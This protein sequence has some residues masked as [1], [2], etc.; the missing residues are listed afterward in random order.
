MGKTI[1]DILPVFSPFSKKNA[2]SAADSNKKRDQ[3]SSVFMRW[4]WLKAN[5]EVYAEYGRQDNYWNLQDLE[6]EAAYSAAYIVGFRKLLP[7]K[8]KKNEYIQ[9]NLELTQLE[10]NSATRSRK[11]QGWYLNDQVRAGYTNQGQLL[12]AGIGTGSN[13]Q[14]LNVSWVRGLKQ[15][16]IQF[17]RFVHNND[18]HNSYI[19][20]IRIHWV[21]MSATLHADWN[22][23]HL[24]FTA[25][26]GFVNS[27]NYEWIYNV[28][29]Y[30][31]FWI[32]GEDDL[33]IHG[34][35][36]LMYRF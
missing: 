8:R 27:M 5:A 21:D 32:K 18:F 25:K 24:V 36:G 3:H 31:D 30:P 2:G 10:L 16:G 17:E 22:Y 12:G 13:L 35:L 14:T 28:P 15:L 29:Q 26:L 23:K 20:D 34:Q 9:V 11:G 7:L 4:V 1:G 33:N 19:P 6:V